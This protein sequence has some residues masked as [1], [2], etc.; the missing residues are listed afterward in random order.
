MRCWDIFFPVSFN[1]AFDWL[2]HDPPNWSLN[3]LRSV[4][5][6]ESWLSKNRVTGSFDLNFFFLRCWLWILFCLIECR[7]EIW[8]Y[9]ST[10]DYLLADCAC[11]VNQCVIFIILVFMHLVDAIHL[12]VEP[13][14]G[15]QAIVFVPEDICQLV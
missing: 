2:C 14:E 5:S 11:I 15:T 10:E 12:F 7:I 1:F 9:T 8:L 13:C 4:V 6:L 3:L